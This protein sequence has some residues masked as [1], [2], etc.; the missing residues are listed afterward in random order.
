M[1]PRSL[2]MLLLALAIMALTGCS[3]AGATVTVPPPPVTTLPPVPTTTTTT[4]TTT[5]LPPAFDLSGVVTAAGD[6]PIE[7]AVVRVGEESATTNLA[8]EFS[9]D[10]VPAATVEVDYPGWLPTTIDWEGGSAPLHVQLEPRMVRGIRVAKNVA[11]DSALFTDLLALAA[12]STV[13][14]LVFDTKDETGY[15]L[16]DSDTATAAEIGSVKPFYDPGLR[17]AQ[18]HDAGLYTITRIVAFE[19]AVWVGSQPEHKLAGAWIDAT[20]VSTWEYPLELADEACR[21]GFDEIQFDYVRFPAGRTAAAA[22][23]SRP[24][25]EEDRVA[26]ISSFLREARARLHPLG[27]AISA[28]IFAIVLSTENDQGIGQRPEDVSAAVDAVSPMVYPSH[29]SDGWLGFPSPNDHP[30]AVVADALDDG[31]P[32]VTAPSLLRPWLQAFYYNGDQVRAEIAEAESR[33]LGWI[34]WNAGGTYNSSWLP[35]ID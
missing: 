18:A 6:G 21:I 20:D 33:G 30:A 15:V 24:L 8:G 34:L 9:I 19:D 32:R 14:T 11:A 3:T 29:Y 17:V 28:D 25:T 27:C 26:T 35:P 31:M 2:P 23:R 4:T 12:G 22:Q 10:S 5:T 13:N 16:Y 7:G 1:N